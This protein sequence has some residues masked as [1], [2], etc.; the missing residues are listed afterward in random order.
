MKIV[1]YTLSVS[2][3]IEIYFGHKLTYLNLYY[4]CRE[5]CHIYS[6]Y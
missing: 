1:W 2:K 4:D 3:R 5:Q 6:K